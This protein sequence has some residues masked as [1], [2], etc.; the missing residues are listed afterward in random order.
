[1]IDIA[2]EI[3]MPLERIVRLMRPREAD[4]QKAGFSPPDATESL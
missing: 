4:L 3:E 1:M 2:V